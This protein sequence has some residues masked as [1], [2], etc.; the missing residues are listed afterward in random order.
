MRSSATPPAAA[1]R[2]DGSLARSLQQ[3]GR[4]QHGQRLC[5]LMVTQPAPEHGHR[6]CMRSRATPPASTIRPTVILRCVN[7]TGSANTAIGSGALEVN[8]TGGNNTPSV[9]ALLITPPAATSH[10]HFCRHNLTTGDNN[11]DIGNAGVAGESS[12]IRIGTRNSDAPP[13]SPALAERRAGRC[14][15]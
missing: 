14:R 15:R 8:T 6:C 12:T 13:L 9:S 4:R 10:W 5:A 1:T 11:I 7:T 2:P 3:H